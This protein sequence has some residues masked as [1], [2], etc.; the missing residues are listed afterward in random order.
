MGRILGIDY[1][2][3]RLGLALSDPLGIT[4]QPLEVI[5]RKS[6]AD[7]FIRIRAIIAEKDV[8]EIV[9]GMAFNMNGS[10]GMLADKIKAYGDRLN[11]EFK[12]PVHYIDERMTTMEAERMLV[13]EGDVSRGKRRSVRDKVAAA[14]ILRAYLDGKK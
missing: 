3:K 8:T 5:E 12:L 7:D 4:A 1:G 13:D 11:E 6:I 2:E 14:L 9:V 10:P